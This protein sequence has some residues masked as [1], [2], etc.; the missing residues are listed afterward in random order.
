MD[1]VSQ[2][3][4]DAASACVSSMRLGEGFREAQFGNLNAAIRYGHAKWASSEMRPKCAVVV[5]I[6]LPRIIESCASLY[7]GAV[8]QRIIDASHEVVDVILEGF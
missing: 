1:E 8:R 7:D 3:L 4:E 6:D 5:S 2:Q